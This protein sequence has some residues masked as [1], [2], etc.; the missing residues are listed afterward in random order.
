M[1]MY[2]REAYSPIEYSAF[3]EREAHLADDEFRQ[4]RE[5]R[6]YEHEEISPHVPLK[7]EFEEPIPIP[8]GKAFRWWDGKDWKTC[9]VP[10]GQLKPMGEIANRK[11]WHYYHT[12]NSTWHDTDHRRAFRE[13]LNCWMVDFLTGRARHGAA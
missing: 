5:D 1:S 13:A 10:W 11:L 6:F 7:V 8:T 4:Q 9:R 3:I 12:W 2:T